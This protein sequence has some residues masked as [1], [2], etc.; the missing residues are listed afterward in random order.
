MHIRFNL[1]NLITHVV[2]HVRDGRPEFMPP[3]LRG[4]RQRV[5]EIS[6]ESP[7][8]NRR[9]LARLRR[10]VHRC[11]PL[12]RGDGLGTGQGGGV[13]DRVDAQHRCRIGDTIPEDL[14]GNRLQGS[15]KDLKD[16]K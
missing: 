8:L 16:S 12:S 1:I 11:M 14:L 3:E 2:A 15:E 9:V 6:T 13:D 4:I 5:G 7:R 10:A